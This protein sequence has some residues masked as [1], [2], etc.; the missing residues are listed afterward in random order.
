MSLGMD[1]IADC[2]AVKTAGLCAVPQASAMCPV[3]CDACEA[4]DAAPSAAPAAQDAGCTDAPASEVHAGAKRLTQISCVVPPRPSAVLRASVGVC[5][6]GLCSGAHDA[7][8]TYDASTCEL[9][10]E[11][12]GGRCE[13]CVRGR[14]SDQHGEACRACAPGS[15]VSTAGATEC[16][17]CPPDTYRSTVG[18]NTLEACA[19]CPRNSGTSAAGASSRD[20]CACVD[21]F[22]RSNDKTTVECLRCQKGEL[23]DGGQNKCV[24]CPEGTFKSEVGQAT[25]C[26]P[27]PKGTFLASKGATDLNSCAACPA[28][29]GTVA[30]GTKSVQKCACNAGY[31]KT[32]GA[33]GAVQCIRCGK[34]EYRDRATN[35]CAA[36]APGTFKPQ[37]GQQSWQRCPVDT[38]NPERGSTAVQQCSSCLSFMEDTTTNGMEGAGSSSACVCQLG[39]FIRS[40]HNSSCVACPEDAAVCDEAGLTL[41][42]VVTSPGYWRSS[43]DSEFFYECPDDRFPGACRGG[44]P[45]GREGVAASGG[46]EGVAASGGNSTDT[47]SR[48]A[49]PRQKATVSGKTKKGG[50]RLEEGEEDEEG[51]ED[52][53]GAADFDRNASQCDMGTAGVLCATC[54]D[55]YI[56]SGDSC[57]ECAHQ[58]GGPDW[59][60]I[61]GLLGFPAAIA[62][63]CWFLS[64]PL[65]SG[66]PS[67]I[68]DDEF[69]KY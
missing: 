39:F 30:S 28:N 62:A 37:R 57:E 19:A 7:Y 18:G 15:Y 59:K 58:E 56:R 69:D 23:Y 1:H 66:S 35:S 29:A 60:I 47:K 38:Y 65:P 31:F 24:A 9:G 20:E 3:T 46:K 42:K 5:R 13:F 55:G 17:L 8:F 12:R 6:A 10:Q 16:V 11:E 61:I 49:K 67:A 22:F 45:N 41:R 14:F 21:G 33:A 26:Q 51:G 25:E 4:E 68:M 48:A 27:C 40:S 44:I 36:C 53:D 2:A 64:R 32:T 50:R 63:F 43:V 52:E 54:A 34:G